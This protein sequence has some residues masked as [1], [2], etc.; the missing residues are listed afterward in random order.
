MNLSF[1]LIAFVANLEDPLSD[2]HRLRALPVWK[3][4]TSFINALNLVSQGVNDQYLEMVQ[5]Y[6]VQ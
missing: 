2:A 5:T 1:S 4:E 6:R 3:Q